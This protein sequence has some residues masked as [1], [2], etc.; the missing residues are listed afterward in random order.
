MIVVGGGNVAVD[1]ALT[2]KK[3]GAKEVR[4]VCLEKL[5]EMAAGEREVGQ[6]REEGVKVLAR[7]APQAI[8]AG[9]G[10]VK[11]VE[12]VRCTSVF[13][14]EG[15]FSPTYNRKVTRIVRGDMVIVAIGQAPEVNFVGE[16]PGLELTKGGWVKSDLATLD[17][18]LPGVFA[19]GDVVAGPGMAIAAIED[20]KKAAARIDEYLSGEPS[21]LTQMRPHE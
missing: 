18:T 11:G 19:G 8:L 16:L 1:A 6:A 2:A 15:N 14:D 10:R 20:G 17:T 3:R 7:W 5:P 4:I 13:D 12:F 21:G 9:E